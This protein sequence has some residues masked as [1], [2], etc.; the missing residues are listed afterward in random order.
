MTSTPSASCC[1]NYSAET[2]P[3]EM[4]G[5]G[6]SDV[7]QDALHTVP[8]PPSKRLISARSTVDRHLDAITLKCLEKPPRDRY[9]AAP[10]LIEDID[11][12]LEW[13]PI[14]A[15]RG[16]LTHR[17]ARF[18]RRRWAGVAAAV[19]ILLFAAAGTVAVHFEAAEAQKQRDRAQAVIRLITSAFEAATPQQSLGS[20]ITAAQI[21]RT[22]NG[23]CATIR[24]PIPAPPSSYC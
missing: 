7:E 21:W 15:H 17:L 24:H 1:M 12:Y 23:R 4:R 5:R 9:L 8:P 20:E 10:A 11:A 16:R 22:V 13:R 18:V 2:V 14:Q 19:L 3:F 6:A